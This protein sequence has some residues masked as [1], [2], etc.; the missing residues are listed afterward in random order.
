MGNENEVT[1]RPRLGYWLAGSLVF[2]L[3]GIVTAAPEGPADWAKEGRPLPA[4]EVLQP[5]LDEALPVYQ[6]CSAEPLE[7]TFEG[8]VPAVLPKLVERWITAFQQ[9]YPAVRIQAP[10]PYLAPQGRLNGSFQKVLDG[11]GDFAFVSRDLSPAD[12]AAYL[13]AHAI[14]VK[15]IPVVGGSWRH[16]GFIDTVGV[17]VNEANP[18]QSLTL[19]QLDAVFSN[20]RLRGHMGVRTWGDLDVATWK[21]KPVLVVGGA[22]WLG[23]EPS[24]RAISVHDK[25]LSV[26]GRKGMWRDDLD[27]SSREAD[28]PNQVASN[29][30]AIGFTGMG[31]LVPGVRAIA[32]S[33]GKG[34]TPI[35]PSYEEVALARYPLSRVGYV[36]LSRKQRRP[37]APA[38]REFV[39][40]I[41]SK[42]GQQIALDQG[43]ML[44][45]RAHQVDSA[46]RELSDSGDSRGCD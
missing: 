11:Q 27:G 23:S 18:V 9:R 12:I 31:H 43:I 30:Y 16:F 8:S 42:E 36:V 1:R 2:V 33:E 39:R 22:A 17:I 15:P 45:L 7:G 5:L 46:R 3:S 44:P 38:L 35:E 26:G 19:A 29:P 21:G 4:R 28:V 6:P 25:V 20:S 34:T 13:R 32:I 10:P 41:L 14:G 37:I 40:F 24:A